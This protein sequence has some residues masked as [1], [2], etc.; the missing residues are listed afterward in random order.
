GTWTAPLRITDAGPWVR[1]YTCLAAD[2]TAWYPSVVA[3]QRTASMIGT[4]YTTD[5]LGPGG[6]SW[7]SPALISDTVSNYAYM[8]AVTVNNDGSKIAYLAYDAIG[9]YGINNSTDYGS[10]WTGYS[11]PASLLVDLWGVDVSTLAWGAGDE[12]HAFL[13]GT[14]AEDSLRSDIAASGPGWAVTVMYSVSADAGV[15]YDTIS[16][17]FGGHS[18]P[19]R[20]SMNGDIVTYFIDTLDNGV[21]DYEP[22][23]AFLDVTTGGWTNDL[24]EV[25]GDGFGTWWYWW[26]ADFFDG[27]AYIAMPIEELWIDYFVPTDSSKLYTF[28]W[29]GQSIMCGRMDVATETEFTWFIADV[30]DDEVLDSLWTTATWRG[31]AYSANLVYDDATTMYI[32]Y[33]DYVDPVFGGSSVEIIKWDLT[34]DSLWRAGIPAIVNA[35]LYEVEAAN[36]V[37]DA[38][39]I[40]IAGVAGSEDSI[41]YWNVDPSTMVFD[42]FV[43]IE[44]GRNNT[45]TNNV[46]FFNVSSIVRN[47]S[48]ISFSISEAGNVKIALYDVT[49]REI[50]SLINGNFNA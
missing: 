39:L 9:A 30:H 26:S 27:V 12:V 8:C 48:E 42:Q 43:G 1:N 16:R 47:N 49:G 5:L 28:P 31:N 45:I 37:D 23:D 44:E 13:G 25:L 38:G 10:T 29:Q 3:N 50:R 33:L 24:G 14:H 22:V 21:A 6:G 20:A 32:I 46:S 17:I 7:A 34:T 40:H 36:L 35:G 2:P 41:Y 11:T 18:L 19:Q 4:W 15:T